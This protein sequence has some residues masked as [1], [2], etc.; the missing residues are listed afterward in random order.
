ML[1]KKGFTLIELII[2][3]AIIGI[4]S[5]ILTPSI[6][7]YVNRAKKKA[8]VANGRTIYLSA[9]HALTTSDTAYDSFYSHSNDTT[10]T[11]Y[12]ATEKGGI[13]LCTYTYDKTN[14]TDVYSEKITNRNK[15]LKDE[16]N[17]LITVVAR[18]DG[19]VHNSGGD[20]KDPTNITHIMNTWSQSDKKYEPYLKELAKD[21]AVK[22][23]VS[24]DGTFYVKMP[25]R[26]REDGGT[27]PLI[28]WLIVYR[29]DDISKVEVWAGDGY[30]AENGPAYRVYPNPSINYA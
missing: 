6:M 27:L 24:D 29:V 12:E 14:R 8:T 19:I 25:Y 10:F 11:Y 21:L 20:W 5:A 3:L 18:V 15:K 30:K 1:K 2:V 22:A 23:N 13:I 17:Y 4:L 16:D 26:K 7:A 28:R 9:L